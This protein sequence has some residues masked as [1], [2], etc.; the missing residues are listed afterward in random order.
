VIRLIV[1]IIVGIVGLW[2]ATKFVP[3]VSIDGGIKIF[4]FAGAIW[5]LLSFFIGPLLKKLTLPLRIITL[6]LFGFLID[7]LLVWAIDIFFPEVIIVGIVPLFWTT[8]I[9]WGLSAIVSLLF[10]KG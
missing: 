3:S 4:I 6:G 2:T 7:M 1:K 8:L 5:G 10:L 9:L